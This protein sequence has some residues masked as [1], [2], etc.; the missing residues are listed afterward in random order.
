MLL[1]LG[2]LLLQSFDECAEAC[3]NDLDCIYVAYGNGS[4][5]P[6]D[7]SCNIYMRGG[8]VFPAHPKVYGMKRTEQNTSR[9]MCSSAVRCAAKQT[10][11]KVNATD[12]LTIE[13]QQCPYNASIV[14]I[15]VYKDPTYGFHAYA[16]T[17][18]NIYMRGGV[19]F[20]A[21]PKVYEM[22]RTDEDTSSAM[23]SSVVQCAAK[24][25][26][27]KVNATDKL[28]IEEQQCPYNASIVTINVYKDPRMDFMHTLMQFL[29]MELK[30]CNSVPVYTR[31]GD[32]MRFFFGN[33]YQKTG[34]SKTNM[35]VLPQP[36]IYNGTLQC[37]SSV[38]I[39][40]YKRSQYDDFVYWSSVP[41]G[42]PYDPYI[43]TEVTQDFWIVSGGCY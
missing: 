22:N 17:S 29:G 9:A 23:C 14:T 1:I 28:T 19:V 3:Y 31:K 5:T 13:E 20:P 33:A 11:T 12:K 2:V 15:N 8:V 27:T 24:Q 32:Y 16:D 21:H 42:Y 41:P 38:K 25:N 7:T 6:T 37:Y 30:E 26:Y 35:S 34:Y 10:Y 36:C 39:R 4:Q 40:E 43:E 18:C